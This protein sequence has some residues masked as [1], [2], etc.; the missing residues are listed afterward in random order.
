MSLVAL[1]LRI[2]TVKALAAATWAGPCVFDS[3]I[4]TIDRKVLEGGRPVVIVLTEEIDETI[5]GRDLVAPD[6]TVALAI[7]A[8]IAG[9]IEGDG[10]GAAFRIPHTD[11]GLELS[12]DLL[13]H[14]ILRA[15]AAA[16]GPWAELWRTLVLR[17]RESHRERGAGD[18]RG[19]RYA[20]HRRVMLCETIGE[21]AFGRAPE[22]A[23]ATLLDL[24]TADGELAGLADLLR[25]E[26][27]APAGMPDWRLAQAR[28]G[29]TLAGAQALGIVPVATTAEG[30][31]PSLW[32]LSLF[33]AP[34]DQE[35]ADVDDGPLPEGA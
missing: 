27:A 8:A 5:V 26:I 12:L 28:L 2:A 31:V 20:A 16:D 1:A 10:P 22:G 11:E 13:G 35:V 25:E 21:P 3:A 23:W 17:V 9:E 4:S 29:L 6:R 33:G 15:L 7:E 14:Q 32:S 30:Q 24:M 19:V 34:I 18:R